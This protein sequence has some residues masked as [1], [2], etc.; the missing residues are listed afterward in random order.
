MACTSLVS[1]LPA[2]EHVELCLDGLLSAD[3]LSG[4][5]EALAWCPRLAV[6]HMCIEGHGGE[7]DTPQPIPDALAL[8][9]L[10]SLTKLTLAYEA[11]DL[12]VFADVVGALVSL[13]G[14]TELGLG[15]PHP[16]VVPAAL[17]QL[18]GLRSLQV[19]DTR[20]AN[21]SC[22]FEAG[23][24]NLPNLQSLEC[25][26][27]GIKDTEVLLGMTALQSLTRIAFEAG[28]GPPIIPELIQLPRLQHMVFSTCMPCRVDACLWQA[29]LPMAAVSSVLSHIDISGHGIPH[30]TA[31]AHACLHAMSHEPGEVRLTMDLALVE[32][33]HLQ[34]CSTR[35][36]CIRS[37]AAHDT[38]NIRT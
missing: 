17:G 29:R 12:V 34:G 8:A 3:E 38:Q 26:S 1:C 27:C 4:L 25:F 20:E 5:L 2:L 10:R 37:A 16:V 36:A 31:A 22:D 6:L 11:D 13:T 19:W 21:G 14:V 28:E 30:C 32:T 9:K 7:R 23:S 18:T 33:S 24:L 35:P 15:V